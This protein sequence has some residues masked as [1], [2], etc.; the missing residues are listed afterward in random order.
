MPATDR[1]YT[2]GLGVGAADASVLVVVLRGQGV[3]CRGGRRGGCCGS[4]GRGAG[5]TMSVG[6]QPSSTV[7]MA[8]ASARSMVRPY[9]SRTWTMRSTYQQAFRCGSHSAASLS[10]F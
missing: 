10:D 8:S 4:G 5:T 3:R 6:V 7:S 1:L 2:V 9:S